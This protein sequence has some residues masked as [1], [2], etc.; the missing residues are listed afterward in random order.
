M[1]KGERTESKYPPGEAGRAAV[2]TPARAGRSRRAPRLEGGLTYRPAPGS[3]AST[4]SQTRPFASARR[5]TGG[6]GTSRAPCGARFAKV[7]F[8]RGSRE[9][10]LRG[11]AF[12]GRHRRWGGGARGR[13][14]RRRR[15]ARSAPASWSSDAGLT[16]AEA[17]R[18]AAP[19]TAILARNGRYLL[20]ASL[21]AALADY[22]LLLAQ[23]PTGPGRWTHY[24][25]APEHGATPPAPVPPFPGSGRLLG[26]PDTPGD[27]DY[28]RAAGAVPY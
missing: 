27:C 6:P 4:A 18:E 26:T 14:G 12:R 9:C 8:A 3:G 22:P 25:P 17:E 13:G 20:W 15:G 11:N 28:R 1:A 24:A 5:R 7:W 16:E 10:A 21:R 2:R 19:M 23:V